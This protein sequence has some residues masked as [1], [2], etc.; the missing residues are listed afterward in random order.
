[1]KATRIDIAVIG[2]GPVGLAL[3]LHAAR[4]LPHA[5]ISLFDRRDA[6]QD[7]SGRPAHAGAVAGQRAT[8]A[9]AGGVAR[10]RGA[11][12]PRGA[13][14]A[15][16]ADAAALLPLGLPEVRIRAADE[17]VPMLGAVLRY[18]QLVA[19]LQQAWMQAA[20]QA[21]RAAAQP[22]RQRG[23]RAETAARRRGAGRRHCR[24]L[25]PGR[26]RR[27]R[28]VRAAGAQGAGARLRP[29]RLGRHRHA[30]RRHA[31]AGDRALH[32]ARAAGAA[33]A[34]QRHRANNRPRWC[35]A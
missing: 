6:A 9:A 11:A 31:G 8:A 32:P 18:G 33:A 25:R 16:A 13:C 17:G 22:L 35:G 4:V 14:L 20:R 15:A 10:D 7:V 23:G 24:T 27:R 34:A 5:R 3:A 12:D 19:P 30:A 1:M 2:A 21:P 26:G 28:R 29:D